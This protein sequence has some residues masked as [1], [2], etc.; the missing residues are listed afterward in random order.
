RQ[1]LASSTAA[2]RSCPLYCS[3]FFSSRSNRVKASAVAP[4][5]P[6]ITFPP[7]PIRRT[8]RA[9]GFIT[10]LP[11]ETWPSPAIT[12][13]PL[14]LTPM[15]VV[16]CH[17]TVPWLAFWSVMRGIW[18]LETGASSAAATRQ[19]SASVGAGARIRAAA[20]AAD[21][22]DIAEQILQEAA[23]LAQ[24]GSGIA[25]GI[26]PGDLFHPRALGRDHVA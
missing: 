3:S 8:L 1:S 17:R 9:L 4:A 19:G 24:R 22:P 13:L 15:M 5:K 20:E 11:M 10:V 2:R 23:L 14:F 12:V 21:L 16:P 6:A 18:A 7:A 25:V 26:D